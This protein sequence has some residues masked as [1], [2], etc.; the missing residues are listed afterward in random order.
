MKRGLKEDFMVEQQ[1]AQQ[2]LNLDE[3]RIES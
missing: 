1:Q 3:K 2:A